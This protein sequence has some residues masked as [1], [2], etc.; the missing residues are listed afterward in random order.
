MTSLASLILKLTSLTRKSQFYLS[1]Y[2]GALIHLPHAWRNLH[3]DLHLTSL[4]LT[5]LQLS[6][7]LRLDSLIRIGAPPLLKL[8]SQPSRLKPEAETEVSD[9][10]IPLD[11]PELQKP[12]T[13]LQETIL[14]V[15]DLLQAIIR[16][17][18]QTTPKSG[19]PLYAGRIASTAKP[20]VSP[21][22]LTSTPQQLPS[23][24]RLTDETPA[25]ESLRENVVETWLHQQDETGRRPTI[26]FVEA[27]NL[28]RDLYQEFASTATL[29]PD[30][31]AEEFLQTPPNLTLD[32]AKTEL[33]ARLNAGLTQE[34]KRSTLKTQADTEAPI[35]SILTP[36]YIAATLWAKGSLAFGTPPQSTS[37][38]ILRV[39]PDRLE[40]SAPIGSLRLEE[41][42][43]NLNSNRLNQ[44]G[45]SSPQLGTRSSETQT[46]KL[47][48]E[49]GTPVNERNFVGELMPRSSE[50]EAQ[51]PPALLE[52]RARPTQP[53]TDPSGLPPLVGYQGLQNQL[54]R[55]EIHDSGPLERSEL[56]S[57]TYSPAAALYTTLASHATT[58]FISPTHGNG[59]TIPP[60][61]HTS[62]LKPPF[63]INTKLK[64]VVFTDISP[65]LAQ[66]EEP[67]IERIDRILPIVES[68]PTPIYLR[69]PMNLPAVES[70]VLQRIPASTL[71]SASIAPTRESI[72][73]QDIDRGDEIPD[74]SGE[75][76]GYPEIVDDSEDAAIR[77]QVKRM[78]KIIAEEARRHIGST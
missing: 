72:S 74:V 73:R 46:L 19:Q 34:N 15:P 57:P 28:Y 8:T 67:V 76:E 23:S 4:T 38:T 75:P 20:E 69:P 59:H 10:A 66:R 21:S 36:S 42:Q 1:Q 52:A 56:A 24:A 16:P 60:T 51:L 62:I 6:R 9:V 7:Q 53:S 2:L 64:T 5:V 27:H 41:R 58:A 78:G 50:H 68:H 63:A 29:P 77:E 3:A 44:L 55:V 22:N 17:L 31:F 35:P 18:F 54:Y 32:Q 39:V 45:A 49:Q 25:E 14:N 40:S 26:S 65:N 71:P 48:G 61:V 70:T 13:R 47:P 11:L 43:S 37:S 33:H 30:R 12:F